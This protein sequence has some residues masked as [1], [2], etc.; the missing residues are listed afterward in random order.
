MKKQNLSLGLKFHQFK[1]YNPIQIPDFFLHILFETSK[2]KQAPGRWAWSEGSSRLLETFLFALANAAATQ[3]PS[4]PSSPCSSSRSGTSLE[5][6]NTILLCN[7]VRSFFR[8]TPDFDFRLLGL[9]PRD[10]SPSSLQFCPS[11]L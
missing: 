6:H 7:K 11:R 4:P 1:Y 9:M 2:E 3:T 5:S 10:S 8:P